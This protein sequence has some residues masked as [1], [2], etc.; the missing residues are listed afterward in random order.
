MGITNKIASGT[1]I[2]GIIN[3]S[4]GVLIEGKF[5]GDMKITGPL[6]LMN[7]GTLDGTIEVEGDAYVFG[8]IGGSNKSTNLV[9]HGELHLTSR[10]VVA[11]TIQYKVLASYVGARLSGSIS[12]INN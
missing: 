4:G 2:Q 9:V 5:D 11:G 7:E 3:F 8:E 12:S 10:C 1:S 6:V